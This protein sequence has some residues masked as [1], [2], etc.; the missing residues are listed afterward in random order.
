[1]E[2]TDVRAIDEPLEVVN[3]L[4]PVRFS[5]R[6]GLKEFGIEGNREDIGFI[7]QELQRVL[8]ELVRE[9][10]DKDHLAVN[11]DH[12]TAVNTAAIQELIQI[13]DELRAVNDVLKAQNESLQER[14]GVLEKQ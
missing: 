5:W 13:V 9:G 14:I 10:A 8:P 3:S 4:N 7:A 11:Y 6:D 2:K 1:V 12:I